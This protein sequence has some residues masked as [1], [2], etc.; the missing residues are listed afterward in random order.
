MLDVTPWLFIFTR[1]TAKSVIK[2][3][4]NLKA[5]VYYCSWVEANLPS[6]NWC[7]VSVIRFCRDAKSKIKK[8][9]NR[10]VALKLRFSP[11]WKHF[12]ERTFFWQKV[13]VIFFFKDLFW[14]LFLLRPLVLKLGGN[15]RRYVLLAPLRGGACFC[16]RDAL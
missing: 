9:I 7:G 2:N 16:A 12:C 1:I 5:T 13:C 11:L 14:R 8:R 3:T 10:A 6:V 4:R 15:V